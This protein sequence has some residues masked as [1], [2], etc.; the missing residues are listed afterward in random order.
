MIKLILYI[1]FMVVNVYNY[2][3]GMYLDLDRTSFTYRYVR[4]KLNTIS[5]VIKSFYYYNTKFII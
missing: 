3:I 2:V 1:F 5:Q 4:I